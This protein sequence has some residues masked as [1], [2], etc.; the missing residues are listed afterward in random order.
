MWKIIIKG[1]QVPTKD[2]A[3]GVVSPEAEAE[4]N[5]D[6]KRKGKLNANG[7][8]M[9]NCAISFKEDRKVSRCK[10]AKKIWDNLQATHEGTTQIKETRID[11]L[12][13]EYEMFSMKEGESSDDMFERFFIISSNRLEAMA[14]TH[15]E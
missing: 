1:P 5:E 11:M 14:I 7:V 8:N 12:R 3:G 9:L 10:T 6:D 15:S 4:W 2:D 13:K